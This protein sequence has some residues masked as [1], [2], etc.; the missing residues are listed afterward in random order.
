MKLEKISYKCDGCGILIG[1][2]YKTRTPPI[3][4]GQFKIC[5]SCNA[6]ITKDG[7]LFIDETAKS[8]IILLQNGEKKKVTLEQLEKLQDGEI[9]TSEL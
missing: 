3:D 6:S 7:Y 5:P 2:A 9:T 4:V 1:P 8:R